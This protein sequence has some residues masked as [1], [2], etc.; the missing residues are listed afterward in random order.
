M[1]HCIKVI[2][3]LA[4]LS[5]VGM[6]LQKQQK[7][8]LGYTYSEQAYYLTEKPKVLFKDMFLQSIEKQ[9]YTYEWGSRV[10]EFSFNFT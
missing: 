7:G 8:I 9:R 2:I 5:Q 4:P 6:Y 10:L 3:A 1:E